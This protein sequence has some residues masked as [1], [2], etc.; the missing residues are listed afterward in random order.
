MLP[1]PPAPVACAIELPW[2]LEGRAWYDAL[3]GILDGLFVPARTG[4]GARVGTD[5]SGWRK[6]RLAA[7]KRAFAGPRKGHR[8]LFRVPR[9][10]P[11]FQL[12]SA[13]LLRELAARPLL[14]VGAGSGAFSLL[15]AAAGGDVV[16][17]DPRPWPMGHSYDFRDR[18]GDLGF[19]ERRSRA[20]GG[21]CNVFAR[22][23]VRPFHGASEWGGNRSCSR[24]APARMAFRK[25]WRD[26]LPPSTKPCFH[27]VLRMDATT[28]L[29][30]FPGRDVLLLSPDPMNDE[31]VRPFL[32]ALAPGRRVFYLDDFAERRDVPPGM[33]G[34]A[35][36][37][38]RGSRGEARFGRLLERD[39]GT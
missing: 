28:A 35:R 16:A 30:A 39:R 13:A 20:R 21:P 31:W 25:T 38:V 11:T 32:F 5:V 7:K 3:A 10:Q 24:C 34:R 15:V 29:A 2:H 19:A 6:A 12:P 9:S 14:E 17:A 22:K 8:P 26:R 4:R 1:F 23:L 27:P 37:E 33:I 18:P 36:F